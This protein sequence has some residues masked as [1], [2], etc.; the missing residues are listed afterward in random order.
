MLMAKENMPP[1]TPFDKFSEAANR[2]FNLPKDQKDKVI[3][4]VPKPVAKKRKH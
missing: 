4:A 3:K 1:K 2:L